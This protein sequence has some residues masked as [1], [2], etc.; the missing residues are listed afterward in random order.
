VQQYEQQYRQAVDDAKQKAT[1]AA[2][3]SAKAVSRGALFG[4]IALLLGAIAAWFG[5]RAGAVDP[6]MTSEFLR[7]TVRRSRPRTATTWRKDCRPCQGPGT[8]CGAAQRLLD[9]RVYD[10]YRTDPYWQ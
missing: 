4:S 10:Y 9:R 5:G 8:A 6:T 2:D 3:V 1:Q 7:T